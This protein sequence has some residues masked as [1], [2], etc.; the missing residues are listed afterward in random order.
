MECEARSDNTCYYVKD[1]I[2][3]LKKLIQTMNETLNLILVYC[4]HTILAQRQQPEI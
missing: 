1:D 4:I 2:A 3:L